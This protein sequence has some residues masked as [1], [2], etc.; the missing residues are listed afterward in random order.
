MSEKVENV[1]MEEVGNDPRRTIIEAII[2]AN[3]RFGLLEIISGDPLGNHAHKRREIFVVV[4]GKGILYTQ[5][6]NKF[7]KKIGEICVQHIS[8]GHVIVIPRYT[9]HTFVFTDATKDA[10]AKMVSEMRGTFEEAGKIIC[11]LVS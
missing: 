6:I 5:K 2:A 1:E 3:K 4:Q 11:E 7:G 10:P 9:A 8:A